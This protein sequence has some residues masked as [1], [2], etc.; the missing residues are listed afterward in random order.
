M[1]LSGESR[2]LL[3]VSSL[4]VAKR[5]ASQKAK[6]KQTSQE[7]QVKVMCAIEH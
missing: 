7:I 4:V 1:H 5:E 2:H 6:I 3:V